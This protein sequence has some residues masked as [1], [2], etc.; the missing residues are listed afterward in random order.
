[1]TAFTASGRKVG[2]HLLPGYDYTIAAALKAG[3]TAAG[4]IP[5]I[6]SP[7]TGPV[8]SG[9]GGSLDSQFNFENCR[10]T[11]FDSVVFVGAAPGKDEA[12][13]VK[14]LKTGRI[15]HVAREAYMHQKA[16]AATGN[17]VQW[18]SDVCLPGEFTKAKEGGVQ[19]EKGV[20]MGVETGTGVQFVKEYIDAVAKHRVWDREVEHIAA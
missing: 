9:N 17:A 20:L 4:V 6:V 18:L 3:L 11:H 7:S 2:I 16:I 10:S 12:G 13:Y 8:E 1:M 19:Q 14:K 15:I 5:M